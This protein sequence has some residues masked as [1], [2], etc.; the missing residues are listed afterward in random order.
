MALKGKPQFHHLN[1]SPTLGSHDIHIWVAWYT[2][3]MFDLMPPQTYQISFIVF[4]LSVVCF[5]I[6]LFALNHDVHVLSFAIGC[7]LPTSNHPTLTHTS[8]TRWL[9]VRSVQE[10]INGPTEFTQ[11]QLSRH[12]T[13]ESW[14]RYLVLP[15]GFYWCTRS[16]PF[17]HASIHNARCCPGETYK[18]MI[19]LHPCCSY[20]IRIMNNLAGKMSTP[21]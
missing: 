2:Y 3:S 17:G 21:V 11:V 19:A 14:K 12:S 7:W 9:C 13:L 8:N 4:M 10:K 1:G 20:A 5:W 16:K 6:C 15:Q 18:Q